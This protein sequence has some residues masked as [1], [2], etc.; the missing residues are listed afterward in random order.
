VAQLS[1]N[2]GLQP[3]Q[4]VLAEFFRRLGK[5]FGERPTAGGGFGPRE[6]ETAQ[7]AENRQQ[8]DETPVADH[9]GFHANALSLVWSW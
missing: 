3:K 1:M 6:D 5:L 7:C 9:I 4:V 2:A 8:A